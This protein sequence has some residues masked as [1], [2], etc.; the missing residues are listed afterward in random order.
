MTPI[1]IRAT[2]LNNREQVIGQS[3]TAGDA[4]SHPFL[5]DR[6]EL[7]D[8]GTFGGTSGYANAVNDAGEVAGAANKADSTLHAFFWKNGVKTDLGTIDGERPGPDANGL[9]GNETPAD[10]V[11]MCH[12][13]LRSP[14]T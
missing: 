2:G 3:N 9:L 6:G 1:R 5:W 7:K 14:P 10:E 4:E 13:G 11:H 8:L 12:G